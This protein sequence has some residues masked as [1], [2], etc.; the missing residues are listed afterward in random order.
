[1]ETNASKKRK[2]KIVKLRERMCE[3]EAQ[4]KMT[5]KIRRSFLNRIERLEK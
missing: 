3:L 4:G 2:A 1:M 5:S